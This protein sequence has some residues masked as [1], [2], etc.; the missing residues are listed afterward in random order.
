MS[1]T[2]ITHAYALAGRALEVF[3]ALQPAATPGAG[4]GS[5][6]AGGGAHAAG[7][8]S[9]GI[10]N[11]VMLPLI[12]GFVWFFMLRPAQKQQK[13]QEA[14]Q[15]S[16]RRGDKVITSAG[17]IGTVHEITDTEVTLE[18]ADKVRISVLRDTVNRK[19]P[20]AAAPTSSTS[21]SEAAK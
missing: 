4:G 5:S 10:L 21:T 18:V 9:G 6:A 3:I 19:H 15:K 11:L 17:I 1:P 20:S 13:A 2:I 14:L 7:G 16:L 12:F 8:G